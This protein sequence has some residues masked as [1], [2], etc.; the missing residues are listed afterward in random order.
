MGRVGAQRP[1][2]HSNEPKKTGARSV[3]ARMRGQNPLVVYKWYGLAIFLICNI[4]PSPDTICHIAWQSRGK[5]EERRP[6]SVD[7][8]CQF[9]SY[10]RQRKNTC[11]VRHVTGNDK[12]F[13]R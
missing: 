6:L 4:Y 8:V 3:R 11:T 5:G 1:V 2:W 12:D 7:D 13:L 10:E 9:F